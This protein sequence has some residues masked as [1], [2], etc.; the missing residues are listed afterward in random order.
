MQVSLGIFLGMV[1]LSGKEFEYLNF[2]KDEKPYQFS[3]AALTSNHETAKETLMY[4]SVL[5][6]LWERERLG[7]FGGKEIVLTSDILEARSL[8]SRP[9]QC[10]FLLEDKMEKSV[11]CLSANFWWLPAISVPWLVETSLQSLSP[12]LHGI[13][14]YVCWGFFMEQ[15]SRGGRSHTTQNR[16]VGLEDTPC[17][18]PWLTESVHIVSNGPQTN[19]VQ[20]TLTLFLWLKAGKF[21][22]LG[23]EPRLSEPRSELFLSWIMFMKLRPVLLN[24]HLD[25]LMCEILGNNNCLKQILPISHL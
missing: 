8:K 11:S 9:Q 7:R 25:I 16:S 14:L 5:W 18:V 6:T 23:L 24:C 21:L 17:S 20:H 4:R 3:R 12:S 15:K 19:P 2:R 10:Q 22:E 1:L 13:I